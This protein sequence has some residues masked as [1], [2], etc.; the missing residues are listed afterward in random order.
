LTAEPGDLTPIAQLSVL[1]MPDLSANTLLACTANSTDPDGFL[2]SRKVQFSDGVMANA[3]GALHA[4][5]S[6]GTQSAT[7]TVTDQFGAT[8]SA[9]DTFA[10]SGVAEAPT[11]PAKIQG[12]PAAPK[13]SQ[14]LR[15]P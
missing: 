12:W 14:P 1:P 7:A 8:D 3:T 10:L 2:I 15:R 13:V 9:S 5:A 11:V 6:P 4:F